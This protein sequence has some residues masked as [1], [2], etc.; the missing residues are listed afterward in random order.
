MKVILH[1]GAHRCA[2]TSFQEYMRHNAQALEKQGIG[3][4][5]PYR[6]RNG[7]FHGIQPGPAPV[8]GR[9]L[10]QRARGRLQIQM[11]ASRENGTHK[12]LVSEENMIGSVR[13]NLRLGDL[14][15]GVGERMARFYQAF[16]GAV[17]DVALSIRSLD[18]YWTSALAYAVAR[19]HKLPSETSL[20]RLAQS[21]RSW[22]DVITDI[23]AAMP[24]ARLHVLPFETFGSRPEAALAALTGAEAP[25]AHARV[26]LNASLCL[27]DLRAGLPSSAAAELPE[28]AGRWRPFN[29]A[30]AASLREAYAD[31]MMWL[32]AGADGLAALAHDPDK[33]AAGQNPPHTR[34]T[35]GRPDDK[36]RRMAGSG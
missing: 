36:Q 35:R 16:G 33:P 17:T 10:V 2:T 1:T 26:R 15:G 22:R 19:G 8:S 18:S 4:W 13:Q 5:G 27:Q 30:Q 32:A 6:T 28:G 3:F 31:D 9:D 14:Y 11:A 23:A 7:L 21:P 29:D 34:L 24:D 25:R 12:L 20:D